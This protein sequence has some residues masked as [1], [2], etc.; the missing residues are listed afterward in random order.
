MLNSAGQG[1]KIKGNRNS[2]FKNI[3]IQSGGNIIA[4]AVGVITLPILARYYSPEAFGFQ[5]Q[6]INTVTFIS[7]IVTWRYEYFVLMPRKLT[8]SLFFLR[9]VSL[10]GLINTFFL[11]ILI[12]FASV[13]FAYFF[14]L[15]IESWMF[16]SPFMAFLLSMSIGLQQVFQKVELYSVSS[17]SEIFNKSSFFLFAF[18]WI[19]LIGGEYGLLIGFCFGVFVKVLWLILFKK[20]FI[21]NNL[22]KKNASKYK[23]LRLYKSSAISFSVSNIIQSVTGLVPIYFISEVYGT[24]TLGQWSLAIS[25]VYLP[26]SIIGSAI[27][28]VYYQKANKTYEEIGSLV[29]I[30]QS[31]FKFLFVIALPIFLLLALLAPYVFP[32]ILGPKWIASGIYARVLTIS[33]GMSFLSTPLDRTCFIVNKSRYPYWI[34]LVRLFVTVLVVAI[35]ILVKLDFTDYL[36][37]NSIAASVLYAVDLY[38]SWTFSKHNRE[39]GILK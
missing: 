14:N 39:S 28:Q 11:T 37:F 12:L 24:Y 29:H 31:T 38:F 8:E 17:I 4:Q 1:F 7:I 15:Q 21:L 23:F 2:Y 22:W 25:V 32:F 6:F 35:A 13:L 36:L 27:G 10:L 5:N 16:I 9:E 33:I 20:S 30:W 26:I 34:N 18:L 19:L 3:I